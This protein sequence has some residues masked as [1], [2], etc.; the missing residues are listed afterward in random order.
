MPCVSH[1]FDFAESLVE[2]EKLFT[3]CE[4]IIQNKHFA[5]NEGSGSP[6]EASLK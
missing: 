3:F 6:S 2:G 1:C 5:L 4:R